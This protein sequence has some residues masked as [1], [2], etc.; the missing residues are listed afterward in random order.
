[1]L[2]DRLLVD[3]GECG[4]CSHRAREIADAAAVKQQARVSAASALIEANEPTFE[5]RE[6]RRALLFERG[7]SIGRLFQRRLRL[8][9]GGVGF[10]D[11]L[12]RDVAL[13]LELPEIAEERARL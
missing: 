7:E 6:L 12:H 1:M 3:R 13:D 8:R 10:G 2:G 4:D 9:D 5:V 11:V